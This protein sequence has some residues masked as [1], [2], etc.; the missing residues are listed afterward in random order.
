MA[1]V[2]NFENTHTAASVEQK[3]YALT[4]KGLIRHAWDILFVR[5]KATIYASDL[6]E[7][8]RKDIG[9]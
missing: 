5:E 1:Q 8:L 2:A 6:P 9:L 4:F 7:H 3:A